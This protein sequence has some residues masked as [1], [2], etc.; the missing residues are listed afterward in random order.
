[1]PYFKT[2]FL[3]FCTSYGLT[4]QSAPGDPNPSIIRLEATITGSQ[5]Q[6]K[7]SYIVPWK[8]PAD[9]GN[10]PESIASD[11]RQKIVS[12]IDRDEFLRQLFYQESDALQLL[13]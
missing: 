7:V 6:P 10:I 4:A 13:P 9:P 1:M 8:K 5:E 12:P 2:L 11:T 3:I